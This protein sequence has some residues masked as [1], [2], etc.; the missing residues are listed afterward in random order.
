LQRPDEF[1]RL[2]ASVNTKTA[3]ISVMDLTSEAIPKLT[4]AF[5]AVPGVES[6]D[7][8]LERSVAV[9][10]FDPKQSKLDD[11]LRVK[12]LIPYKLV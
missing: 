4:E 10:E 11:L 5:K 2:A 9:V 6:I 8:S 12:P 1:V 3:I 7:Y